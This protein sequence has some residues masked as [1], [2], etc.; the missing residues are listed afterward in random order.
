MAAWPGNEGLGN[1][2]QGTRLRGPRLTGNEAETLP[3]VPSGS[4]R[5]VSVIALPVIALPDHGTTDTDGDVPRAPPCTLVIFGASGDLTKRLLMPALYNLA[6]AGQLSDDVRIIGVDHNENTDEG[7]RRDLSD[8][9]QESTKDPDAEFH[10]A[11]I[12]EAPWAF[13]RDRLRYHTGDFEEAE[14]F[15]RSARRC[16]GNVDL[17]PRGVGPVLRPRGRAARQRRGCCRR[18]RARFRRVVVEKPFGDDLASAQGAQRAAPE[19]GG[20]EP[21][22]P[23][24]PFPGQGDGAEHHGAALR[25]RHVGAGVEAGHIEHVRDHRRRDGRRGGT[26]GGF[27]E[28]TGALRDMVPNHLFQLLCMV[29]MEPPTSLRRRSRPR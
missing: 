19:A 11:Q 14:T 3:F 27:Y 29:A 10:P 1:E 18:G 25:Q 12:D 4:R 2:C 15:G 20:R 8:A 21:D 5:H 13:V 16:T 24:R 26:R 6:E 23:D 9:L 22:L 17:L 28:P 7:W